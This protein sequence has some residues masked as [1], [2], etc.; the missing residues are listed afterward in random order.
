MTAI[1]SPISKVPQEV[2]RAIFAING[3]YDELIAARQKGSIQE[4]EERVFNEPDTTHSVE[5]SRFDR[6]PL[7]TIRR[8]SQV[9]QAWRYT[10]LHYPGLWGGLID[11][12]FMAH[13]SVKTHHQLVWAEE[14]LRRAGN[15][16]FTVVGGLIHGTMRYSD[17]S[18]T[19]LLSNLFA[20]H[21]RQ[22][23][24]LNLDLRKSQRELNFVNEAIS[25]PAERLEYFSLTCS[26]DMG[27]A[28]KLFSNEAPSLRNFA[29]HG[30]GFDFNAPWT[31]Q[32]QKLTLQLR[33]EDLKA[34]KL[35]AF[36]NALSHMAS[37]NSLEITNA[38]TASELRGDVTSLPS[39]TLPQLKHLSITHDIG[40]CNILLSRITPTPGRRNSVCAT[41]YQFDEA[42]AL[43]LAAQVSSYV[44]R[45]K[46]SFGPL[47]SIML[48]TWRFRFVNLNFEIIKRRSSY[49]ADMERFARVFLDIFVNGDFRLTTSLHFEIVGF[50]GVLTNAFTES[51][52][53][54]IRKFQSVKVLRTDAVAF[55]V[56]TGPD[57]VPGL[58]G[59]PRLLPRLQEL[60]IIGWWIDGGPFGRD[61]VDRFNSF[62]RR[63]YSDGCERVRAFVL[64]LRVAR[65]RDRE[66]FDALK[67]AESIVVQYPQATAAEFS[68]LTFL[69]SSFEKTE[70]CRCVIAGQQC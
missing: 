57:V 33:A 50:Q 4:I 40:I 21:W 28:K 24:H 17:E 37:L 20:V 38:I 52:R 9:C 3:S 46:Y 26:S 59:H 29:Y 12:D 69:P 47:V 41:M 64:D 63:N 7:T 43:E 1:E 23:R 60:R 55:S 30:L 62:Y 61:F 2:L 19:S 6:H 11:V 53:R 39:I 15:S 25:T 34:S 27:S 70:S 36:L 22:I 45:C 58:E 48:E 8:A 35:S 68:E 44:G 42:T 31:R 56:V 10:I 18:W 5:L 32:L 66:A 14:V 54:F 16:S 67:E 65:V 49:A 13:P 51:A